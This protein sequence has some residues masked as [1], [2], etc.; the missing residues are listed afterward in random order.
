M[1]LSGTD[2]KSVATTM[3]I[4]RLF[5]ACIVV[6]ATVLLWPTA[7]ARDIA[8]I[9]ASGK[10]LVAIPDIRNPPFF[11]QDGDELKGLDVDL[12]SAIAQELGV[13]V[14]FDR[15]ARSF[16]D[17]VDLVVQDK[18]DISAAKL[19]RTLPRAQQVLFSTPYIT[20]PHALL[21]NRLRF[22]QI[23]KGRSIA[24]V[25]HNYAESVGVIANSSFVGFAKTYFPKARLVELPNWDALVDAVAR[26]QV[27][28]AY[29]DAFEVKR[30]IRVKP[31]LALTVQ[32]VMI[33]DVTDTIGIAVNAHNYLLLGFIN[34][35][36]EQHHVKYSSDQILKQY[37]AF[38][39]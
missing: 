12:A 13:Q 39:R 16:N 18:A 11:F 8:A 17:A 2:I 9:K 19:S 10:L 27:T 6:L 23:G 31:E 1:T 21:I 37:E 30:I 29:R 25:M 34:Q 26:G 33:S 15:S 20:L 38:L 4:R 22:A 28:I 32:A 36:L 3:P 35:F 7:H 14:A 5:A 24:D